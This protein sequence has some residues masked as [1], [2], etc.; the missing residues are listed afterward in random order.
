MQGA[1]PPGLVDSVVVEDR[2]QFLE[3]PDRVSAE[4]ELV[5]EVLLSEFRETGL[6]EQ[7]FEY[8]HLLAL[9]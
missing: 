5:E 9:G 3:L 4:K 2:D 6:L 1:V 8:A 7:L